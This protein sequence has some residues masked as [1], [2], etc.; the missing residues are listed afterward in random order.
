MLVVFLDFDG[1]INRG[2]GY[3]LRVLVERLNRITD[4]TGAKIVVHSSWRWSRNL[5]QIR[6]VLRKHHEGLPVSGEVYDLCPSP[7][8]R[9]TKSGIYVN[10]EN[11]DAFRGDIEAHDERAIAIQKWLNEHPGL[12]ERYVI[13]DDSPNLGHFVGTPEFIRTRQQDG[14][15][16]AQTSQAILH[17]KGV[18]W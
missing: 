14:L 12:V 11:F 1:V 17:L 2:S 3:W 15:S 4:Q 16:E 9:P 13:L 7:L 6:I 5:E 18:S 10:D 8:F